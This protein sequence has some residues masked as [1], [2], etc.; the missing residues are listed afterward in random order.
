MSDDNLFDGLDNFIEE[1]TASSTAKTITDNFRNDPAF[2]LGIVGVGQCGNNIAQAF[3]QIGY[4]RVLLINT[5]Q[6]DLDAIADQI[7]K[8]PIDK[9]GAGKDP[10]VGRARVGAKQTQV[11]NG[12]LREFG[13]DF[14]KIIVCIGLGGGTGSG[15]G[16]AVVELA[17][18]IIKDRGGDPLK[19]VIVI[20]T[21]PDPN[22]DGPRQC[23]N[24]LAA[25]GKIAALGVS[26]ITVDNSQVCS[27]IRSKLADGWLPVN[28][29]IAKTFHMFNVYANKTSQMGQFDG[30]DLNDI[31]QRGR[32]LFSA[33]RVSKLK[34]RYAIGDVMSQN[35]E[36]SLFAK[37]DLSTAVA[38]GCILVIN[39]RVGGE[40]GQQD[41]APVFEAL[42]HLMRP[43]STLHRGVYI[44]NEWSEQ[45][46]EKNPDLFCYVMLGGLDHPKQTLNAVFEKARNYNQEYGTVSAF[47][48]QE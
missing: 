2:K 47:L 37:C 6:T 19:D 38:A 13:D 29:W 1:D 43:N 7:A 41:I 20:V 31:I 5:A 23:F 14:D 26:M 48:T 9:Q 30:N 22:I 24:A 25:Y 44:P 18:S 45:D 36:R 33:F 17:K 3:H 28:M 32:L 42:N 4:R 11:R 34:D 39:P 16:P 15:G 10:N 27:I 40:L 8:L 46:R 21:L 35:L 12:M